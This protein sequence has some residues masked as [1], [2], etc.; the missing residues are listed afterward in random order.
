MSDLSVFPF[1]S[2][3]DVKTE[4]TPDSER[5][6]PSLIPVLSGGDVVDWIDTFYTAYI[7]HC[8]ASLN[9]TA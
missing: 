1:R 8:E 4:W 7:A 5:Y 2:I 9:L 3:Q 6:A